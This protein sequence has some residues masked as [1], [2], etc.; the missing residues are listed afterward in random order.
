MELKLNECIL[1]KETKKPDEWFTE[2][3]HIRVLLREDHTV[4]LDN[5]KMIQHILYNLNPKF[6]ETAV[7]TLKRDLRYSTTTP[8]DLER[9]KDEIRQVF[10]QVNKGKTPETALVAG[11]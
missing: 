4:I 10:G 2:L 1:D 3:E 7:F 6:Y 5:D 11:K 8:L 9:V